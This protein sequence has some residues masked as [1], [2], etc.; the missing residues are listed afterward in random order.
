MISESVTVIPLLVLLILEEN[1]L[2]TNQPWFVSWDPEKT[3]NTILVLSLKME[4]VE[5]EPLLVTRR[6]TPT[7]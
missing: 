3:V 6:F 4:T 2:V 7:I 5:K 1:R